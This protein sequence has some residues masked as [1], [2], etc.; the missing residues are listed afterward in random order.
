MESQICV[1]GSTWTRTKIDGLTVRS[2]KP[3]YDTPVISYT[4]IQIL[5]QT[6]KFN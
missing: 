2:N 1:C 6:T 3:L 4:N 5:C